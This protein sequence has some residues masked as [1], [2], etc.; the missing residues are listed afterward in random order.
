M[1][2]RKLHP[3][4]YAVEHQ[5]PES[6]ILE[7]LK[8]IEHQ[9]QNEL[10]HKQKTIEESWAEI[11]NLRALLAAKDQDLHEL[12]TRLTDSKKSIEGNRQL[13]NKLLSDLARM[14]QDLDWYKRTYEQRSLLGT[15]R[16]KLFK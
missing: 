3:E 16:Q 8:N 1:M 11:R 5:E 9:L 12:Q 13:I 2:L 4:N 7:S 6:G 15:I 14:R 10:A